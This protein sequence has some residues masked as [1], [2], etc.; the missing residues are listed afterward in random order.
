VSA[1]EDRPRHARGPTEREG[2]TTEIVI[3]GETGMLVAGWLGS[4][5]TSTVATLCP[6]AIASSSVYRG[7]DGVRGRQRDRPSA[8]RRGRGTETTTKRSPAHQRGVPATRATTVVDRTTVLSD[9]VLKSLEAGRAAIEALRKLVVTVDGTL[10]ITAR[11]RPGGRRSSTPRWR[12]PTGWSIR[13]TISSARS[14][15]AL[16]R[17]WAAATG[18][19]RV[20]NRARKSE[21]PPE[22]VPRPRS[23]LR[24]EG[25]RNTAHG[26]PRG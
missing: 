18:K 3:D 2:A 21:E 15:T 20:G 17:R 5:C 4:A 16:R 24:V 6:A 12:W 22:R 13:S 8:R 10:P 7:I 19:A 14:S 25:T 11:G 9:Q 26:A 1:P 23:W